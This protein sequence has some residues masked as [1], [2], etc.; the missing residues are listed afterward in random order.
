VPDRHPS[1]KRL[2]PLPVDE[3]LDQVIDG[4]RS[5]SNL[6]LRAPTGAGKTTRVAPAL[7]DR[8]TP[9]NG[10]VIL[11]QPRRMAARAVATRI[12]KE[13]NVRLGGEIGYRVR[14]DSR[15]SRDTRLTVMTEG[16]FL[17]LLQDNPFLDGIGTVVFDEFHERSLDADLALA[18]TAKVQTEARTDLQICVMSATLDAA[19]IA[20]Y[21]G[22]C[23]TVESRGRLFPVDLVH[24]PP[25]TE[26]VF[27]YE[28]VL[29]A[30][31]SEALAG[32]SGDVLVFLPGLREIR[33]ARQILASALSS[34]PDVEIA[35]LYGDL[36]PERQDAVLSPSRQRGRRVILATNVAET[37]LT[38]SGITA[39]VDSGL[40]KVL[41]FDSSVGLDRLELK[42]I[43]RASAEQR[44]G[45]AGRTSPG[46][47]F[48][49]WS[50]HDDRSL[51]EHDE[52]EIQRVDLARAVLQLRAWGETSP[53]S[54]PWFE[55][56]AAS[57]L[58]AADE[59]L[60]RLGAIDPQGVTERGRAMLALPLPPRIAC[61]AVVGARLGHPRA[62]ARAAAVLSEKVPR[63][64]TLRS[65]HRGPSSAIE[66]DLTARI[67]ALFGGSGGRGSGNLSR[68]AERIEK[69][70]N[71]ETIAKRSNDN[72]VSFDEALGRAVLAGW[73]DRVGRRREPGSSRAVMTG[74]K[75][76]QV[77]DDSEVKNA[78]LFVCLEIDG[79]RRGTHAE[80]LVRAAS[81]VDRQWL[82]PALLETRTDHDFDSV[83]QGVLATR[84]LLY[85]DLALEEKAVA[86][87][88]D[89][90]A[91]ALATAASTNIEAAFDLQDPAFQ[92]LRC[93]IGFTLEHLDG[94]A[95][96]GLFQLNNDYL[97]ERLDELCF[98]KRSF[99]ELRRTSLS[100]VLLA[101]LPSRARRE[102]ER[103]AP[104]AVLLPSGRQAKLEYREDGPPVLAAKIQELFG[105]AVA[106]RVSGGKVPV[107]V[108]LLA[109]NGRP[110]QMTNDLESFWRSG[111]HEV[112][113]ELRRRYPKHDWPDD[114]TTAVARS[115]PLRRR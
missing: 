62:I 99:A 112:R 64:E 34:Q 16:V 85:L 30:V 7:L 4:I 94:A 84:R 53:K 89:A 78:E 101:S 114:P 9:K 27:A 91:A 95:E 102:L 74:G 29:A 60:H 76:L 81:A 67:D 49:L 69:L 18:L 87:D 19:P 51:R 113:K 35:E 105:M 8:T 75:G 63:H 39:V 54:F 111:Y 26:G 98:G 13:R 38:I 1:P 45:R 96:L 77:S 43:S 88:S 52:A 61:L 46:R 21:L 82:A 22:N 108:H 47:C 14:F 17:R 6:V 103:Q 32:D 57:A 93:R 115:R 31:V 73:P 5:A 3:I 59:L 50:L 68:V 104:Q 58:D 40:A 110:A 48:R 15:V 90:A 37:S 42:R 33:R 44:R 25:K 24:R 36:T 12:A 11:L 107:V 100:D 2:S 28:S 72:A 41:R 23:P 97:R 66:S 55:T 71:E 86:V 79:G 109:P 106:P 92:T 83:K 56:P 10:A 20:A 80:A 70:L 65:S